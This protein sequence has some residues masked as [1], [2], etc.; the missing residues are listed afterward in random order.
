MSARLYC[1]TNTPDALPPAS[2]DFPR[3]SLNACA[4]CR[5]P[6][7]RRVQA[8]LGN[9]LAAVIPRARIVPAVRGED[10]SS[11]Q[12]TVQHSCPP[13]PPDNAHSWCAA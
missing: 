8:A 12:A 4:S 7:K 10:M 2:P 6:C 13:L 9:F 1:S 3:F 11:D 5:L